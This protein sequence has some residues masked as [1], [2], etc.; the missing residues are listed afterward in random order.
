M[1]NLIAHL[2][3]HIQLVV[4]L[5]LLFVGQAGIGHKHLGGLLVVGHQVATSELSD[6][7]I[8]SAQLLLNVLDAPDDHV[9][10]VVV[11]QHDVGDDTIETCLFL[12]IIRRCIGHAHV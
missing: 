5:Y 9:R 4:N 8:Q 1:V 10:A 11:F 6:V 7:L 3:H 2:L 12:Q